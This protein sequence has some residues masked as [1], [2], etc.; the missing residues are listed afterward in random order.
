MLGEQVRVEGS[1][2]SDDFLN[3]SSNGHIVVQRKGKLASWEG[4]Q[5][6]RSDQ[7]RLDSDRPTARTVRIKDDRATAT[8]A[9]PRLS[10][11]KDAQSSP[12]PRFVGGERSLAR[13][14]NP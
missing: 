3:G 8:G 7:P 5:K 4:F 13:G 14:S 12:N 1:K 9:V 6:C 2:W 11:T 10:L